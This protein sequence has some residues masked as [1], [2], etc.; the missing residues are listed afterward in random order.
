MKTFGLIL[1][2]LALGA[3]RDA[4]AQGGA[5]GGGLDALSY[6]FVGLDASL[7]IAA[8][9]TGVGSTASLVNGKKSYRWFGFSALTGTVNL[10]VGVAMM[11]AMFQPYIRERNGQPNTMLAVAGSTHLALGIWNL[12]VAG[13]GFFKSYPETPVPQPHLSFTPV[14]IGGRDWRGLGVQVTGF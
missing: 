10:G 13:I 14:F 3:S 5:F 4:R 2:L 1:I 11:A 8:G 9:V 12:L 6:I 7:G